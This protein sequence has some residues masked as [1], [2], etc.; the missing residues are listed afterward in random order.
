[1]PSTNINA[2]T[3][4]ENVVISGR[5]FSLGRRIRQENG[6]GLSVGG[7][8]VYRVPLG[9]RYFVSLG[10]DASGLD[11]TR[12]GFDLYQAEVFAGPRLVYRGGAAS[13]V[14]P[15]ARALY[16]GRPL[17]DAT[18][19]RLQSATSLTP[20]I[21]VAIRIGLS[22]QDYVAAYRDY[23]G[24]LAT[25][26]LALAFAIGPA[27]AAQV[28]S[29]VA[30]EDARAADLRYTAFGLGLALARQDLPWG[31]DATIGVSLFRP[32]AFQAQ[33]DGVTPVFAVIRLDREYEAS[34]SL[35]TRRLSW[36]GFEPVL[37]YSHTE[38]FSTI[39]LYRFSR[40]QI[41]VG[42]RRVF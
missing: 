7:A 2:A 23:S 14:G 40:D 16:A 42:I 13:L 35:G 26:S 24:P 38:H 36:R 21:D 10:A 18:G 4:A 8:A 5:S 11:Y 15:A 22:K 28:S 9:G 30:R 3:G 31:L 37:T 34:L 39:A 1:M 20:R 19:V 32:S 27:L 33:Y 12:P 41:L 17:F 25:L 29:S 6:Y